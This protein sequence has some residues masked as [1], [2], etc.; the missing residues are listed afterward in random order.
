[1]VALPKL[2]PGSFVSRVNRFRAEVLV[3]GWPRSARVGS[4]GRMAE[5]LVA[6]A[7]VYL[8]PA[9]R[10]GRLTDY[11]LLLV[12]HRGT[13]VSVD[14]HLPNRLWE[15]YLYRSGWQGQAVDN[16]RAEVQHG[17]SRLDFW[18]GQGPLH[19][20]MEVKS[21][22]LVR[23]G[24]ALFP[25]APTTRGARHASELTQIAAAGGA[26]AII[27]VV[28]RADATVFTPHIEADPAFAAALRLARQYGV[29]VCAYGCDVRL[30]TVTIAREM[31]V[32]C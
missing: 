32:L 31:P 4:S 18:L 6:G 8:A 24:M 2:V 19:T 16:L 13:L 21:V 7:E 30:D 5:L 14:A 11:D 15:E 26:A 23:E 28:Q 20:W 10:P 12:N 25:D 17:T 27:F 9:H 22:T 29:T 3:E 1:M